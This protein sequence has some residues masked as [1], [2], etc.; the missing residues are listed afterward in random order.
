MTR[1]RSRLTPLPSPLLADADPPPR[2]SMLA[3]ILVITFFPACVVVHATYLKPCLAS[4]CCGGPQARQAASAAE[5]GQ[6]PNGSP[7]PK[8]KER[9]MTR[10]L[11]DRLAPFLHAYRWWLLLATSG[12]CAGAAAIV[13]TRMTPAEELKFF[14]PDHPY[15]QTL[16][17]T[18][19]QFLG[20]SD[21]KNQLSLT[22]GLATP[23][24]TYGASSEFLRADFSDEAPW[25]ASYD[26]SYDW[27]PATQLAVAADC[28]A[29]KADA[30]LVAAG[31]V[32]CLLNELRDHAPDAFP[33]ADAVSLHA[34]LVSFYA[35]PKYAQLKSDFAGY[36]SHTGFTSTTDGAAGGAVRALFHSFNTTIPQNVR[37][38]P[39][40]MGPWFDKWDAFAQARCADS[41]NCL[42]S[43][44][45]YGFYDVLTSLF[46]FAI[47]TTIICV[48][49]SFA[50]L[51]LV[52]NN[53]LIG[54]RPSRSL[55][56]LSFPRADP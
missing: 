32:Y 26:A 56:A 11:R 49:C 12:L 30:S 47:S 31:E 46:S 51:L 10:W 1:P 54:A 27:G 16:T 35:A 28:D 55:C 36:A 24:I 7:L 25:S 50:V 2:P 45:L 52:T 9:F 15:Q 40:S 14:N 48:G 13:V 38:T 6:M 23:P 21:W 5:R 4:F 37:P 8:R 34:A 44:R 22:Y 39:G 20:V 53:V 19:E 18:A 29:A 41:L 3:D 17:I 43:C 33:Y 42:H